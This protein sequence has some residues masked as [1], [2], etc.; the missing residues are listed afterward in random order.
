MRLRYKTWPADYAT[1][2]IMRDEFLKT[3]KVEFC[4]PRSEVSYS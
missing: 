2:K 3:D 1:V 4:Y